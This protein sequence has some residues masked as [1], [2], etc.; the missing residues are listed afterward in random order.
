MK[1]IFGWIVLWLDW[2]SRL[3]TGDKSPTEDPVVR[4]IAVL[5][6]Q[7]QIGFDIDN[8]IGLSIADAPYFTNPFTNIVS[9]AWVLTYY[10]ESDGK[11]HT[12]YLIPFSHIKYI[13]IPFNSW[14]ISNKKIGDH[15]V[16]H[17]M[18]A[19]EGDIFEYRLSSRSD[20]GDFIVASGIDAEL[21]VN[22]MPY[23]NT[24]TTYENLRDELLKKT[25]ISGITF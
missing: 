2:V 14:Y 16:P 8:F 23:S 11:M 20:Y 1:T 12:L 4:D 10:S 5:R 22:D 18:S 9:H 6:T 7:M 3:V 13:E 25:T 21:G 19:G 17:L 24:R 15:D